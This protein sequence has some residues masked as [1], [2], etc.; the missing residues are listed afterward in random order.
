MQHFYE[1]EG[2]WWWRRRID[3]VLHRKSTGFPVKGGK[4]AKELAERAGA[5]F[6]TEI[7]A[8]KR[9]YVKQQAP[10]FKA[11]TL[12]F[13]EAYYPNKVT[14]TTIMRR[15]VARWGDTRLDLLTPTDLELYFRDREAA[16]AKG[17]TL[18][19]ERVL[20]RRL[21]QVAFKD[22]WIPVNPLEDIKMF[23]REP[24]TRVVTPE[25]EARLRAAMP[26]EWGRW[27]RVGIL[28]GMRLGELCSICPADLRNHGTSVWV[29]GETNKVKKARM[30]PLR[31][32]ARELLAAQAACR[33]G[34]D[35]TPYW[36]SRGAAKQQLRRWCERLGIT[37]AISAHALR[38]TFA[39]RCAMAGLPLPHLQ[40]LLGHASP[41]LTMRYYVHLEE[42]TVAAA[43]NALE[44]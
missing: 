4:R 38:R 41:Q 25:E 36:A 14:E 16:G 26:A 13:L 19:R 6:L 30:I 42:Q 11:W 33:P 2:I 9:G 1:R 28:T 27:L 15:P 32:E 12:T 23:K 31:P 40:K 22:G 43:L 8:G 10:T 39:T 34:S 35:T 18:E 24:K 20:L 37:P 29:R 17:G 5:E 3:G 7:K 21:F 44:L